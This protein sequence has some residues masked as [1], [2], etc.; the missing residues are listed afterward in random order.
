V[1]A[2]VAVVG[3]WA[4]RNVLDTDR[5]VDRVAPTIEDPAV[6]SA[7]AGYVTDRSGT[8]IVF[9]VMTDRTK[10]VNPFVTEDAL[11]RVAAALADC[12]CSTPVAG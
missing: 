3:F 4:K 12:T 2:T 7:L 11:D 5:F 6:Q 9:A 8:P 1:L 10:S